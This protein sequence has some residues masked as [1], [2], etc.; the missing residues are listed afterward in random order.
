MRNLTKLLGLTLALASATAM[1]ADR[2]PHNASA[3]SVVNGVVTKNADNTDLNTR[4]KNDNTLTPEKQGN[5]ES[6]LKI[7]AAVRRAVVDD[8]KLSTAA[9]NVKIVVVNGVV[10]LRGPVENKNEKTRVAKLARKVAGVVSVH[11]KLDIDT[12]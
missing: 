10:T 12:N 4:D 9:H 5:S 6:D 8:S 2:L 3:A 11:N 1:A 7:L